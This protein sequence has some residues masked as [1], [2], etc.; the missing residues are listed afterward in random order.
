MEKGISTIIASIIL[1]VITIGLIA[2]AYLYFAGIV[3]VGPVITIA[4]AYCQ[5]DGAGYNISVTIKNDGTA[6]FSAG[7]L[8]WLVDGAEWTDIA[9]CSDTVDAGSTVTCVIDNITSS[10]V[11]NFMAI[12]PKNQAGGPVTC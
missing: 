9:D 11:H 3:T 2:T 10:G 8:K 4:N 5:T 6:S 12:G 7:D 1:V